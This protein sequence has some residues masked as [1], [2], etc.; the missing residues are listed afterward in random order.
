MRSALLVRVGTAAAMLLLALFVIGTPAGATPGQE[1]P[2]TTVVPQ[3]PEELEPI[4]AGVSPVM[5]QAC[6]G[7]GLAVGLIVLAGT[8]AG[9][10]S[11]VVVPLNDAIAA[12]SG[13]VLRTFFEACQ[14]IPLPE[15]PPDCGT[16][17]VLPLLPSLGRPILPAALLANELRALDTTLGASGVPLE[18]ALGDAADDLLAC[19]AG[20]NPEPDAVTPDPVPDHVETG[21]A[22][23]PSF[24]PGG[25]SSGG[26][27]A[28]PVVRGGSTPVG[29]GAAEPSAPEVRLPVAQPVRTS[30]AATGTGLALA[31]LAV[32]ALAVLG[33]VHAGNPRRVRSPATAVVHA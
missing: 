1:L 17:Q 28:S 3:L 25:G 2:P 5:W 24:G 31:L 30:A 16:D 9:A 33:W 6:N 4:T 8:L 19:A 15:E 26:Q 22:P 10:P 32:A 7:A 29:T 27:T 13:P 12:A 18:G 20:R 21:V 11:D 23:A 14:Q